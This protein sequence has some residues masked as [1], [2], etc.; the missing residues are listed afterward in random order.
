VNGSFGKGCIH[1]FRYMV[2]CLVSA[3]SG[4]QSGICEGFR[5]VC[6]MIG[7]SIN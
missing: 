5:V 4:S 1:W 7:K 2:I 6:E 3:V